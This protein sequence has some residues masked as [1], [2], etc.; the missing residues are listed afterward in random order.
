MSTSSGSVDEK[1]ESL[2]PELRKEAIHY[3]DELVRRSKRRPSTPC[4][5][6][7]EGTLDELGKHYSSVDLQHKAH[8]WRD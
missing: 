5:C 4:R 7:A 1:I 8:E 3:I 6:V 2:P